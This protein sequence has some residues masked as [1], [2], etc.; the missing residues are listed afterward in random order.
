MKVIGWMVEIQLVIQS[1]RHT[2]FG[3]Q[4]AQEV[5]KCN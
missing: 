4:M 3:I 2:L 5:G 1:L